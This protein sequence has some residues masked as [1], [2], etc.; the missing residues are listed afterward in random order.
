MLAFLKASGAERG[1]NR[2]LAI[3][4]ASNAMT[5]VVLLGIS[6]CL[7]PYIIDSLGMDAYGFVGLTN[8]IVGYATILTIALNTMSTRFITLSYHEGNILESNKYFSSTFFAN[9]LIAVFLAVAFSITAIFLEHVLVI[10]PHLVSDVKILFVCLFVG[11]IASLCAGVFPSCYFIKNRLDLYNL[12]NLTANA[13]RGLVIVGMFALLP[14]HLW[15]MGITALVVSLSLV[16]MNYFHCRNLVPELQLNLSNFD[17]KCV[18]TLIKSGAWAMLNSVQSL[19]GQGF[20]LLLANVFIGAYYLGVLSV[21]KTLPITAISFFSSL[22][23]AFR[24]E[25]MKLYAQ[26]RMDELQT[27]MKQSIRIMGFC[28]SIPC[29]GIIAYSDI[30]YTVWL[31]GQDISLLYYISCLTMI[32]C[33]VSMPLGG[34]GNIFILTDKLKV[35]SIYNLTLSIVGFMI[36]IGI[37]SLIPEPRNKVIVLVAAGETI[38]ILSAIGFTATYGAHV[39]GFSKLIF[40]RPMIKVCFTVSILTLISL[41]FKKYIVDDYTWINLFIAAGFTCIMGLLVNYRLMLNAE[42]RQFIKSRIFKRKAIA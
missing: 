30:F 19:I 39:L 25:Y 8:G 1:R 10:P 27:T 3:N 36:S 26:K 35:S 41:L 7:S 37:V 6:F 18:R 4:F 21:S 29:A 5:Y 15:Y 24:P 2:Q 31:P 23:S 9:V 17:W 12:S 13:L 38:G 11:W 28:A 32:S 33:T 20:E 34:L 40:Y 16:I 42:D 22:T 14:P